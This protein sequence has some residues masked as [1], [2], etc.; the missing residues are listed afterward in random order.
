M[1]TLATGTYSTAP[2]EARDT[3]D[4]EEIR[5]CV[6]MAH[7]NVN[8]G[9]LY[10]AAN[11]ETDLVGLL[12]SNRLSL[13][14]RYGLSLVQRLQHRANAVSDRL[15]ARGFS[16]WGSYLDSPYV[17]MFQ[18][19]KMRYPGYFVGLDKPGEISFKNFAEI[20][21]VAEVESLLRWIPAWFDFFRF[22]RI[23]PGPPAKGG[24]TLSV[25]WNTAF[26]RS[27]LGAERSILPLS[28]EEFREFRL[29]I[30]DASW[31]M[32]WL[33]YKD[34]RLSEMSQSTNIEEAMRPLFAHARQKLED[35]L[36]V[37]TDAVDLRFIEGLLVRD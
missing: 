12:E 17:E 1:P 6:E 8:I 31:E 21:E 35:I 34:E 22:H 30:S 2:A 5:R 18:G 16:E 33:S 15:E 3:G 13:F 4:V 26:A 24:V 25:L 11:E 19:V 32:Q 9:L 29:S 14:F 36:V 20:S 27:V 10:A 23:I 7:D 28:R 37:E